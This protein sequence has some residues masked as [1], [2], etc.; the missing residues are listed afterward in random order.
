MSKIHILFRKKLLLTV[1]ITS[2]LLGYP[3]SEYL[4]KPP[5][6]TIPAQNQ[7][8]TQRPAVGNVS[9][10]IPYPHAYN[11]VKDYLKNMLRAQLARCKSH[12]GD[13][14]HPI[15]K[16]LSPSQIVEDLRHQLE[17]FWRGE[18]PFDMPVKDGNSLA[19]WESLAMHRHA[20][21]LAVSNANSLVQRE[22]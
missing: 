17:A 11:R 3:L 1:S 6:I 2:A 15:F 12:P 21:I 5:T 14:I 8:N 19:W 16:E 22:Y 4:R 18:W 10:T 13:R 20:R 9:S 7:Q